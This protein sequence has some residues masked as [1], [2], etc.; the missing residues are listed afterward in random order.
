[1][2]TTIMVMEIITVMT[3]MI[4]NI[5]VRC[6][7]KIMI[8]TITTTPSLGDIKRVQKNTRQRPRNQIY[9]R[10]IRTSQVR[11]IIIKAKKQF[12]SR[13]EVQKQYY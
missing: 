9:R 3:I 11:E 7:T 10:E 5:T 6:T 13:L 2:I 12:S 8:I 4:M 1:M